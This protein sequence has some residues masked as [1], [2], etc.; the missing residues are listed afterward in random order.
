MS[1]L[2]KG[3]PLNLPGRPPD[4]RSLPVEA[5]DGMIAT[6][7]SARM[8]ANVAPRFRPGDRI[9]AQ[10]I[11]PPTHTRLPRYVRGKTG[12]VEA[13][14]GVFS[15]NDTN[16]LGLGHKPQHVY[17]VQFSA[18]ELWGEQVHRSP[19]RLIQARRCRLCRRTI[20]AEIQ[21]AQ[22]GGDPD[23][24]DTYYRHWLAALEKIVLA[25]RLAD[26]VD[27]RLRRIECAFNVPKKH[28]HPA[29]RDPVAIA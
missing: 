23:L 24:G 29:K 26:D 22:A 12:I 4:A 20:S 19:W 11:N 8:D 16:A 2:A 5:V 27:L 13:D 18:R 9:R 7:G 17:S 21:Q 25:K 28:G 14:R 6:G 10:N 1:E 3:T 15:F